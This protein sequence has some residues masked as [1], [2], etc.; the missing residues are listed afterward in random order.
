[1]GT[2]GW[3]AGGHYCHKE[4][5][6]GRHSKMAMLE[7]YNVINLRKDVLHLFLPILVNDK[8]VSGV[9]QNTIYTD[10]NQT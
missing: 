10:R 7:N 4:I 8:I 5:S 3:I 6:G 9:K 1:M 2:T